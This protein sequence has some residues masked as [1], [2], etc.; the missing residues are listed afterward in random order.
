MAERR[1]HVADRLIANTSLTLDP[2][3]SHYLCRVLRQRRGD[4]VLLFCGD[5]DGYVAKIDNADPRACEVQVG[6]IAV[7]EPMPRVRLH[8]AQ[9]M[10]KG[11]RLDFVLQKATELGATD[12]WLI[13]TERTEARFQGA[14]ALRRETHWQRIL[15][16]AAEQCGRLRVP[17]LHAPLSLAALLEQRD[18]RQT[19]LLDPGAVPIDNALALDDTM[20]LVGPEGGFSDAERAAALA[21]GAR[22]MGLGGLTL[23]ADTAPLAALAIM[24]QAW[25]WSAP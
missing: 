23:R 4:L 2:G 14:R 6:S 20:L 3:R 11:D 15:T 21:R 25:G 16:S 12:I 19:L 8:L 9:A 24:R 22:A 10:L 13:D 17:T 7:S 1:L 5:G 18:V